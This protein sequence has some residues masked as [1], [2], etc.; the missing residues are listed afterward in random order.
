M[1]FYF[2]N[3]K[4]KEIYSKY[5]I[6]KYFLY[7]NLTD[8]DSCFLTHVLVCFNDCLIKELLARNIIFEVLINSE[9]FER[10]DTSHK[11]WKQF[12]NIHKPEL[13]KQ[14]GLYEIESINNPDTITIVINP[15]EYFKKFKNKN[16]DKKHKGL[17]KDVYGMD[18]ESYT[19][20]VISLSELCNIDGCN[21]EL[22]KPEKLTQ[23]RF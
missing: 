5:R 22:T 21:E 9:F 3:E 13:H 14:A 8:T 2:P 16:L 10:L 7:F 23:M 12:D 15:K 20:R 4:I 11:F 18:F 17:R 19:S 1:F 6:I